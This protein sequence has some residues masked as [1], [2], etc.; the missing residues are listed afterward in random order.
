[1]AAGEWKEILEFL[2]PLLMLFFIILS[3]TLMGI[4]QKRIKEYEDRK[5]TGGNR[6]PPEKLFKDAEEDQVILKQPGRIVKDIRETGEN[7]TALERIEKLPPLQKAVIWA[8][9][10]GPP[11]GISSR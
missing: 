3:P 8:D 9:I 1:M 7:T 11:G 5:K 10:L 6:P 4:I 2:P